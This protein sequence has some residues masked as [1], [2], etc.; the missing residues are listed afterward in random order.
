M[1]FTDG[2]ENAHFT[3]E[4][5]EDVDAEVADSAK[6]KATESLMWQEVSTEHIVKDKWIDFR[7]SDYRF[8][9]G[10]VKGPY[11]TLSRR[12]YVVIVARDVDGNYLCVRQFRQGINKVTTEFT[13]GGIEHDDDKEYGSMEDSA[14]DALEAAKRELLEETGYEA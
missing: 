9:D 3:D 12:N 10:T 8:P 5:K 13:A 2:N 1:H 11:Y 4:E 6:D 14:E 7:K